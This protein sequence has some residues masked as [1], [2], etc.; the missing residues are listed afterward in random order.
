M[1]PRLGRGCVAAVCPAERHKAMLSGQAITWA[2][3]LRIINS[4]AKTQ[5]GC[6]RSDLTLS[7]SGDFHR[8]LFLSR[9]IR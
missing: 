5:H 2:I 4:E 3:L 1:Q 9:S 7:G 6:G 8:A